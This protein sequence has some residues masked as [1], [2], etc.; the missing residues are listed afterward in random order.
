MND[1][2]ICS[3]CELCHIS[4][5]SP[6]ATEHPIL[7]AFP[8]RYDARRDLPTAGARSADRRSRLNLQKISPGKAGA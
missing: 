8:R 7:L 6:T 2:M 5:Q 1:S 4:D 3:P